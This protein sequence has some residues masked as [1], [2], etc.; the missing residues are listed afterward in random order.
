MRIFNTNT[1]RLIV[2]TVEL[3][4]TGLFEP[5]GDCRI[6]GFGGT[7]SRIDV[8]FVEP[9]GSMTGSLLPTGQPEETLRI[10]FGPSVGKHDVRV[11]LLD[12]A[13][14]FV[15]VDQSSLPQN[16]PSPPDSL[17]AHAWVEQIRRAG[18]VRYG[19]ASTLENAAK[20]RGT[21]KIAL[22]QPPEDGSK[23]DI[24]V[25]SYSMG[26]PH[27][28]LQLT[29]AV[30][31]AAALCVPGTVAHRLSR[32]SAIAAGQGPPTPPESE[33]GTGNHGDVSSE[34]VQLLQKQERM[35]L[36]GHP[37]GQIE[38]A[39][40][41]QLGRD[42]EVRIEYAKVFRTARRIF[43]GEVVVDLAYGRQMC[44]EAV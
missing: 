20:V 23:Q 29:G 18:A 39:I 14:P 24:R 6:G 31:L 10:D 16:L 4:E 34:A 41:W 21:P 15:F 33:D 19:L 1:G 35:V 36:V 30:C 2:D 40:G 5:N 11:T 38:V 42:G 44:G 28:S 22:L 27:P 26:K 17:G 12:A 37:T 3:D 9:A 43:A 8:S 32:P 13:N 25:L 7:G